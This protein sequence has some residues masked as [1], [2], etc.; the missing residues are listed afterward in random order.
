MQATC[1]KQKF[2]LLSLE[3]LTKKLKLNPIRTTL[4]FFIQVYSLGGS[5][6]ELFTM[7]YDEN[8]YKVL[9]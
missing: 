7:A 9:A 6:N 1:D 8:T 3:K 4:V 5:N 2:T